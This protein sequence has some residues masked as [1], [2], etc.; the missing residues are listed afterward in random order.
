[1]QKNTRW[2]IALVLLTAGLGCLAVGNFTLPLSDGNDTDQYEYVGYFFWKNCSFWPFPQLNL[3]NTQ[4]FYPYGTNQ[5]FLDWGFERDYWYSSW[6]QCFG[7]PGPYLQFYYLYSLLVAALG[8]FALLQARFGPVKGFWFGL[9][10]SVLNVYAI[11]KFPVHMNICVDHWTVLCLV[12]TYRLLLDVLDQ[13]EISLPFL[14]LWIWLHVQVLSQELAY[15]AGFA[16]SFT[17]ITVPLLLV[18]LYRRIPVVRRWPALLLAYGRTQLVR[19]PRRVAGSLVLI[20]LSVWLYVPLT[21][22]IAFTA[23][24]FDFEAVPALRA[25]SHPVRLLMPYVPVPFD[26]DSYFGDSFESYGQGSPGLYL[27]IL[28]GIGWWQ[29]RRQIA[30]WLPPVLLLGLCL[31]YHPVLLPTLKV[32]PWFSFNRH[33]GRASL[34]YP[35]LLG[36]LALPVNWPRQ[37]TFRVIGA[38]LLVL[39]AVEWYVGF[40]LRPLLPVNVASK[41]LIQ[42]CAV[43]RQ[44]PGVAVLDWP[45]CTVGADG[46]GAK[47]GLCPYYMEQNAV[48]TFRR[49]YDKSGV[50]Q[51][52]GRLHPNQIQPF[53]RDGWPRLLTPGRLFTEQDWAFLDDFL[54]KNKFA[55]INLYPGLLTPEQVTAFYRHYGKPIAETRFPAAGRVVFIP[56]N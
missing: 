38:M 9:I 22:Q 26:S 33:G 3:T 46:T 41:S 35:V 40:H 1:M 37:R 53:L 43:V 17:T 12:A 28:A 25:W 51:Y 52:F 23:W 39:M 45:F 10:V 47:E 24:T 20:G 48:F 11:W 42:Y 14:L 18:I 36:L 56:L 2:Y 7:G 5:V 30:R 55:G 15:V 8:S 54:Q 50:G 21:L 29:I 19:H 6:Y 16:L 44:Q 4:T 49:F 34:I 31:L 32:F 13:K 27:T